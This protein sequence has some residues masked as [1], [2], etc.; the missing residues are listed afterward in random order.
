MK[1]IKR[2]RLGLLPL[3]SWQLNAAWV[4]AATIAAEDAWMRLLLLHDEPALAAAE[5]ETIRRK[6]YHLPAAS[7]P[8]PHLA[9]GQSVHHRLAARHPASGPHLTAGHHPDSTGKERTHRPRAC[10]TR[11]PRSACEGPCTDR[12]DKPGQVAGSAEPIRPQT[13]RG[14]WLGEIEGIDMT[15]TFART[16]Q[17]DAARLTRRAPVSLGIPTTRHIN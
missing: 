2:V 5:L 9:L 15:L 6:L 8:R 11:R 16:I 1:A 4:L 12:P 14:Q 13:N 17:T 7:A 3:T 10:G